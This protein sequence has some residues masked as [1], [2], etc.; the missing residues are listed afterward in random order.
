MANHEFKWKHFTSEII[1]WCLRWFIEYSPLLR[2]KSPHYQ[3]I[4]SDSSWQ[5]DAT[6]VRVRCDV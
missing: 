4:N 5:L 3:F 2:K 1:L 6:Y